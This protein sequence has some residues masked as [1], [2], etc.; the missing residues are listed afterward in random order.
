MN[1]TKVFFLLFSVFIFSLAAGVYQAAGSSEDPWVQKAKLIQKKMI[2]VDT[3]CD[4]AMMLLRGNW[5]PA[6]RHDPNLA[7][8]GKIDLPRMKEGGLDCEFFAAFV[9]QGPRTEAGYAQAKQRAEELIQAV[10]KMVADNPQV[11]GLGFRPEDAYRLKKEGK[12]TAFLGIENGY[13]IGQDLSLVKHFYDL[14]VRYITLCHTS[15]NDICD[16]S[17]DPGN[18]Q[19][20]GLSEFGRQVV[21]ECN[22][23]GMIVDISHASDK[24]FYDVLAVSQAPIIASHSCSRAVCDNPRNLTDDMIKALAKK[25]GVIQ[26]CFLSAYVKTPKP[27]PE[28]DKALAEFRAKYGN[29][30]NIQDEAE[31]QKIMEEMQE[32]NRK[33]PADLATVKDLV[34]HIDHVVK[35]VGVDYVG[36]GTDFDGGGGVLGCNDVSEMY[37]VTAELLRR[38]YSE[39]D[40]RKIWGE[41]FFRVFHKVEEVSKRLKASGN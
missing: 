19:D 38:G 40:L 27:N 29:W 26:I 16:S 21:R 33:Y 34:D 20:K 5:N 36:I 39:K 17:T 4:T 30:R 3:H 12:L 11:I 13:A 37:Q 14:G 10:K 2:T 28:R 1:Q 6:E 25:G 8:S 35:L 22:R 32:L 41:N 9:A 23:L 15:N 24:S 31:R 18:H 7:N